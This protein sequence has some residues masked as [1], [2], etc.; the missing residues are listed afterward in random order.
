M[1]EGEHE[2]LSIAECGSGLRSQSRFG[3]VGLQNVPSPAE[4]LIVRTKM[5]TN[6]VCAMAD[7]AK[8]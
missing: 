3:G 6:N 5:G 1:T 7:A 4:G 8:R 2:G